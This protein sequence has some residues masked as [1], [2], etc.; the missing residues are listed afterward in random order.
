MNWKDRFDQPRE[1]P[2][3]QSDA[4]RCTST[5]LGA[6]CELEAGHD[7]KDEYGATVRHLA[8]ILGGAGVMGWSVL[9]IDYGNGS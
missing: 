8:R 4:E 3:A 7:R 5:C 2:W 1:T 6:R 9:E